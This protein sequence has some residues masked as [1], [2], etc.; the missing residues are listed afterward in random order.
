M[1]RAVL[2]KMP[3][4]EQWFLTGDADGSVE[5]RGRE[6]MLDEDEEEDATALIGVA[7]R[8][9]AHAEA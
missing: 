6:E 8:S 1:Y 7:P 4:L 2:P 5:S 9:Q 3:A